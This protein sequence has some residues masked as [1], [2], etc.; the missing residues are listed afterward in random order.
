M[1]EA[2]RMLMWIGGGVFIIGALLWIARE[3]P[4]L[5]RLPG[6]RVVQRGNFTL[7]APFGTMIVVR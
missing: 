3:I 1:A 4:W 2:G 6:D 7:F 5:G